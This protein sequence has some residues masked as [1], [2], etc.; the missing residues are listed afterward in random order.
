LASTGT[1]NGIDDSSLSL[2][3]VYDVLEDTANVY[4]IQL[5]TQ[6]SEFSFEGEP[7]TRDFQK[8]VDFFGSESY[9]DDIIQASIA[10]TST[11]FPTGKDLDMSGYGMEARAGTLPSTYSSICI[12]VCMRL[13]SS[14]LLRITSCR[15]TE[16]AAKASA[17]MAVW[18]YVLREMEHAIYLCETGDCNENSCFGKPAVHEVDEAVAFYAGSLEGTDG[19]G[20]GVLTYHLADNHASDFKTAGVDGDSTSGTAKANYDI[21]TVFDD[22]SEHIVAADCAAT[23]DDTTRMAQLMTVP[24][25]QGVLL[26]TYKSGVLNEGEKAEA[27][28]AV[29]AATVLPLVAACSSSDADTIYEHT[30][31]GA[32]STDFSVVKEALERN[33]D[34]LGISSSDIGGLWD[35]EA[36]DYFEGAAPAMAGDG[37]GS[38]EPEGSG[39]NGATTSIGVGILM[40]VALFQ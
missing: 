10:G 9:A 13:L 26:Y 38:D 12:S 37:G 2:D 20:D 27:E 17:Y 22:A 28:R 6:S 36:N 21:L 39:A 5:F 31:T 40:I 14:F 1:L 8:F 32:T 4:S 7:L 35:A 25:I 19:S 23:R 15:P 18:M 34:C 16:I 33:Y 24:L 29:F 30:K 3:Y 11:S